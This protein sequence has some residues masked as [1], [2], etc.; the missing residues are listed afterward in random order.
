MTVNTFRIN[1]RI[2]P[3]SEMEN[4][5]E[6]VSEKL[7][8]SNIKEGIVTIFIPGATGSISTVEY[9]PGL[10]KDIPEALN[11]IAPESKTY[12]H[13]KTWGDYNGHGHVRAT[14]MGPGMTVPFE[15]NRMILGKWQQ[16]VAINHDDKERDREIVIQLMRE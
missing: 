15:D 14:I 7:R 6:E 11:N 8:R 12:E 1:V 16:I 10:K 4:I 3:N 2:G 13:H 9:E 5:T